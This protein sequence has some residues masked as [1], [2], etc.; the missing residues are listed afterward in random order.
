MIINKVPKKIKEFIFIFSFLSIIFMLLHEKN[1]IHITQ[2]TQISYSVF[3]IGIFFINLM[4]F[5][6]L[7]LYYVSNQRQSYLLIL[8]F[9]FLSNTYYLLEVAIISLSP[10]GNDLST[11]YQKSNDIAIYYLFR[12]FSFI[13]IIFLAIYSTNVKNKSIL[14]EKRNII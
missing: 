4:V 14:E 8:S 5:I 3:I 10:I 6:F 13:S 12:Q 1:G 9:A 7:L 2:T 11:T